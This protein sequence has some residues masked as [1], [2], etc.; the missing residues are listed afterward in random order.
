MSEC[1]DLLGHLLELQLLILSDVVLL[2]LGGAKT[3]IA[4]L[5]LR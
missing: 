3:K 5:P 1:K 4:L 2:V